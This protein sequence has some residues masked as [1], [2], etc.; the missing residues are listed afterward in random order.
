VV[1]GVL[2]KHAAAHPG[3][4]EDFLAQMLCWTARDPYQTQEFRFGGSL[5]MGGKFWL[6]PESFRVSAYTEDM[7]PARREAITKTNEELKKLF[8]APEEVPLQPEDECPNCKNGTL[9]ASD[10]KLVCRGECGAFFPKEA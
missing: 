3:H 7:T 4:L 2:M 10:D 9:E 5:G 1:Y 8:V 6:C